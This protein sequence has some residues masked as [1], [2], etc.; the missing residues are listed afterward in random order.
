MARRNSRVRRLKNVQRHIFSVLWR[1][2]SMID[3]DSISLTDQE[4]LATTILDVIFTE[5]REHEHSTTDTIEEEPVSHQ[6]T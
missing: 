2:W 6:Q 3:L 1:S 5:W 4:L